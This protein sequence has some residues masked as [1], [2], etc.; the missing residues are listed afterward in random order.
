M[1]KLFVVSLFILAI[2]TSYA[3]ECSGIDKEKYSDEYRLCKILSKKKREA[4]QQREKEGK[5]YVR[6]AIKLISSEIE[7]GSIKECEFIN[8]DLYQEEYTF[9]R[10]AYQASNGE[11][12]GRAPHNDDSKRDLYGTEEP[13]SNELQELNFD[14][15]AR[16][17]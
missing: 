14:S 8:K 2:Q 11:V 16:G 4:E 12:F 3:G 10:E 6:P 13:F 1:L 9:C 15:S 17:I 5:K 7:E